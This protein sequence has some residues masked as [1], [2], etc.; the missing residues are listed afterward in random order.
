MTST[1]N[2]ISTATLDTTPSSTSTLVRA[3]ADGREACRLKHLG[4][5]FA[6]ASVI[7]V[8]LG[9]C[10]GSDSPVDAP[11][12]A[13]PPPAVAPVPPPPPAS[14]PPAPPTP[15]MA[16]ISGVVADGPLQGAIA[17]YDLNNN[18]TCD[19]GDPVSGITDANGNYAIS[20]AASSAGAHAVVVNVPAGAVDLTTGA[21]IGVAL[22]LRAPATNSVG[23]QTVFVSPLSTMVQAHID[24][25]GASLANAVAFIQAQTGLSL[26]P[27]ADFGGNTAPAQDAALVARLIVLTIKELAATMAPRLGQTDG[28]GGTITQALIDRAS[29][30]AVRGAL[31]TLAAAL[32][33]PSIRSAVDVQAALTAEARTLVREQPT[34]NA[35]EALAAAGAASQPLLVE[36][37]EP[38]AALRGFSYTSV[39]QWR[40]R[41]LMS[42]A[43]DNTVDGAGL[44]RFYD[45]HRSADGGIVSWGFGT[46]ADRQGDRHWNGSSWTDC[47]LFFRS[48]AAPRDANGRALYN[49][50]DGFEKGVSVQT[51]DDVSGQLISQVVSNRIRTFPGEDDGIPYAAWGPANLA[52]FGSATFPAGSKLLQ[53]VT[54]PLETVP[55]YDVTNVVQTWGPS[56]AAGG[57]ARGNDSL[58]C[59]R[60]FN[61]DIASFGVGTLSQLVAVNTG[62]PCT[63]NPQTDANGSS[64]NPNLWWSGTS[65]SLGTVDGVAT[66]PTGTQNYFTRSFNLRV[67]FTGGNTVNY[68]RCYVRT[69]TGGARSCA[70]MGR[71]T[72]AVQTLGDANVMTFNNLPALVQSLRFKRVFVERGGSVYFG[73]QNNVGATRNTLRLNLQAANAVFAPLGIAPLVP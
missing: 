61:A 31:P 73:Y 17:C 21:P 51:A 37:V 16:T 36:A 10:G 57:D 14:P 8:M 41:A 24:A 38:T 29:L 42:S 1:S 58:P 4:A 25:T 56:I 26:S 70:L 9:G 50:C 35:A 45:L 20:V 52:V 69:T 3:S 60:A 55:S 62:T 48:T 39:N 65:A 43:A 12:S 47:P 7:A 6:Q 28:Q 33:D 46:D 19:S 49:Y 54:T 30:D 22:T 40:Y 59:N 23:G 68:H 66:P 71:G 11:V 15:A 34:L 13:S 67:A 18:G 63:V 44:K 72:Y 5:L 27:L 2:S 32:S 53:Q 64:L